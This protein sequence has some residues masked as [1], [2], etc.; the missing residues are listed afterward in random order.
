MKSTFVAAVAIAVAV[1]TA[2]AGSAYSGNLDPTFS[3]DG[4]VNLGRANNAFLAAR[5][6]GVIITL[7]QRFT[8][9]DGAV[10]TL[11]ATGADGSPDQSFSGD[12]SATP[13][14]G[15]SNEV[16]ALAVDAQN[17]I[18]LLAYARSPQ[19]IRLTADGRVDTS[20]G[21]EGKRVLHGPRSIRGLSRSTVPDGS[22]W[23]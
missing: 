6:D 15:N 1:G 12:G 4:A 13:N 16:S 21:V 18:L 14:L 20:F 19:I 7:T 9:A 17:R 22:S 2:T 10:V 8:R 3:G 23:C 11:R 5:S